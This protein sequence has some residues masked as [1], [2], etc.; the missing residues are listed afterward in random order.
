MDLNRAMADYQVEKR[1]KEK[2]EA[3]FKIFLACPANTV[4]PDDGFLNY[5]LA[6]DVKAI[7]AAEDGSVLVFAEHSNQLL[8]MLVE[9]QDQFGCRVKVLEGV[10][11]IEYA[12]WF[13]SIT[14]SQDKVSYAGLLSEMSIAAS[15][16]SETGEQSVYQKE[17]AQYTRAG[18][19]VKTQDNFR[20]AGE[21]SED[22][23]ETY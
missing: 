13:N 18:G 17:S 4:L 16:P 8:R 11:N 23:G 10:P 12:P 1:M 20:M 5:V 19:E 22:D 15:T 21:T 2:E 3:D 7:L 6:A 9:Y 14:W